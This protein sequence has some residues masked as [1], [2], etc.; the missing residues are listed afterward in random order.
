MLQRCTS[1][2]C[3]WFSAPRFVLIPASKSTY[4]HGTHTHAAV[5]K[6]YL[7]GLLAE[8]AKQ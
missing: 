2:I 8:S 1:I 3:G 6:P 5:C 4:G 7:I